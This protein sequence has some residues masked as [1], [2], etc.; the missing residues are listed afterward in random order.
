V[1]VLHE[2]T[3][4]CPGTQQYFSAT[5]YSGVPIDWTYANGNNPC[6][7]VSYGFSENTYGYCSFYVY[8]P[9]GDATA[10]IIFGYNVNGSGWYGTTLDEN[11][12]SGW[13]PIPGLQDLGAY[14][15][16]TYIQWSD[17]DGQSYPQ[18]IGWGQ[19]ADYSILE[20]CIGRG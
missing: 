16:P 17:N 2:N 11:P 3:S 13:Q 8:V 20:W 4:A 5:D 12:V 18:K 10:K 14:G 7:S 1:Q 6:I 19:S 15:T 9:N